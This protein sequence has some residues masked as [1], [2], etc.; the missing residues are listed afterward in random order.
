MVQQEKFLSDLNTHF[1]EDSLSRFQF[2]WMD[3]ERFRFQKLDH[4]RLQHLGWSIEELINY[5]EYAQNSEFSEQA[6]AMAYTIDNNSSYKIPKAQ[7]TKY[8]R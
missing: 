8:I 2:E 7:H 4:L 6:L 3:Q 5:N 1:S